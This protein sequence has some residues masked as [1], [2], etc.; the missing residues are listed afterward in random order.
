MAYQWH[1]YENAAAASAAL[2]DAA[3]AALQHAL[4][5]KG[6]AVLAVSGGRSPIAFFEALSQKNLDWQNIGITLVDER[7]VPTTHAD[8]NT[9]LV[10]RHLLQNQAAAAQW[11]PVVEAGTTETGLQPETVVQTALQHYRQP[12]V[13]VLGMGGDGHTASL[14]PQAPQLD[15]GLDRNNPTP[16]LHT[17]PV[18]APHERVSMTLAAI[19][20]TPAVFLAI[21]GAEKKAVFDQAAAAPNKAYPVSYIIN[22]EKVNCHVYYAA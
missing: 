2:A 5:K 3:E 15:K 10:R 9:G 7:I 16:L 19:A 14:F 8:S 20:Q 18:T 13:L 12:D 21:G 6:S 17:T 1:S 4:N 22:H 11:I